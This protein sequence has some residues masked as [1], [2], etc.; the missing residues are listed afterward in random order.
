VTETRATPDGEPGYP[1]GRYGRRRDPAAR[2]TGRRLIP[3]LLVGIGALIGLLLAVRLYQQYGNPQ[4]R[5]E[6]LGVEEYTD[7][8][9]TM[10]LRVYK[11]AGAAAVCR[12]RARSRTGLPVGAADVPVPAGAADARSAAV[13]FRLTTSE[14]PVSAEVVGCRAAGGR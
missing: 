2:S 4:Y 5:A 12:V 11:P 14:R 3:Y 9:V 1:P 13:T 10:R 8:H 7:D 6:V